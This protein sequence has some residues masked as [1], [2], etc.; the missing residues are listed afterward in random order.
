MRQKQTLVG[1]SDGLA[2]GLSDGLADCIRHQ[3]RQ[4]DLRSLRLGWWESQI[5]VARARRLAMVPNLEI[6]SL[7]LLAMQQL[8]N[9]LSEASVLMATDCN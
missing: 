7:R 3:V 4:E 6:P 9:D 8:A 2:D 1:L 5:R